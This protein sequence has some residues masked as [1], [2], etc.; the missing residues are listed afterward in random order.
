MQ[1]KKDPAYA[2]A[3][4]KAFPFLTEGFNCIPFWLG[5]ISNQHNFYVILISFSYLP[6]ICELIGAVA[7]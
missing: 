2:A 6:I 3:K 4:L 1:A 7:E 5:K